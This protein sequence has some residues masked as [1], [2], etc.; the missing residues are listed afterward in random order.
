MRKRET[1]LSLGREPTCI[2][3]SIR[4]MGWLRSF[5]LSKGGLSGLSR[6]GTWQ[7]W[8][9]RERLRSQIMSS[10]YLSRE[11][12][13]WREAHHPRCSA[14]H[15][16]SMRRQPGRE[17]LSHTVTADARSYQNGNMQAPPKPSST[18]GVMS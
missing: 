8:V 3:Y 12:N 6:F 14:S 18:N 13:C 9:V 5:S 11:R 10:V 1:D 7:S 17:L 15:L 4:Q 16:R 2:H